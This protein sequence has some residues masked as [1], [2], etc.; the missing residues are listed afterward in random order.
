MWRGPPVAAVA[1]AVAEVDG[2]AYS[3]AKGGG[4]DDVPVAAVAFGGDEKK[5]GD[6]TTTTTCPARSSPSRPRP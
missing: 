5:V 6:R 1:E 2:L 3:E 4:D